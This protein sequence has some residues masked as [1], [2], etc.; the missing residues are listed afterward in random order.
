MKTSFKAKAN[1]A[2]I[3]Y[4]GKSNKNLNL[5]S[6]GSISI[7][8]DSLYSDTEITFKDELDRDY[9]YIDD[10]EAIAQPYRLRNCLDLIRKEAKINNYATVR[11]KNNFPT[12]SGLASSASGFAAITMAASKALDLNLSKSQLSVI[13][14]HGSGSAARSIFGGFVEMVLGKK[15]D[16]TDSFAKQISTSSHWP[17]EV[18]IA[19]TDKR[20]KKID[21]RSAMNLS[22]STSPY[23]KD[24]IRDSSAELSMA[25][26]AIFKKDFEAL[27][28]VSQS[29]C[30]KMHSVIMTTQPPINYWN[31]ATLSCIDLI[32]DLQRSGTPVFFTIDAGPQVKA[33]CEPTFT[34]K[35]AS[36]LREV[37]GVKNIIVSKLDN[38]L[39]IS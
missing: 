26:E 33:I 35:V 15:S 21:S 22:S 1:I 23:Y 4:W 27:S 9:L 11:S 38:S 13:A 28:I 3:K 12:S 5:P 25:R 2:L 14:R 20:N 6:T 19:I 10:K 7:T 24:W 18:V 8:L 36:L 17:L 37:C 31:K 16:G 39:D 34:S 29:N 30:L 32:I